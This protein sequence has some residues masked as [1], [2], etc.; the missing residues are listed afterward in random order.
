M[1]A[2][3]MNLS[4]NTCPERPDQNQLR[5][6]RFPNWSNLQLN[7][8]LPHLETTLL[9][10]GSLKSSNLL[11]IAFATDQFIVT[12]YQIYHTYVK[13]KI[14]TLCLQNLND[15]TRRSLPGK[16]NLSTRK[17][18]D[19]FARRGV[20]IVAASR[21]AAQY[22]GNC[23]KIMVEIF[24]KK[25]FDLKNIYKIYFFLQTFSI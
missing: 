9:T 2:R 10:A 3:E 12:T 17:G 5:K 18:E 19:N 16:T 24:Y 8:G 20:I 13:S 6:V 11:E 4:P 25:Y 23:S 1:S 15:N 7:P 21:S 14:P 22:L